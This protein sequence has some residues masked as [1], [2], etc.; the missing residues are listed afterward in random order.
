MST[1]QNAGAPA[2]P[3]SR[4]K[5]LIGGFIGAGAMALGGIAYRVAALPDGKPAVEGGVLTRQEMAAAVAISLALFPPG[6]PFDIDGE[7]ADVA[8]YLD[9]YLMRLPSAEQKIL[10]A[11]IWLYDQGTVMGGSFRSIRMMSAADAQ[12][13][14]RGWETSRF[15]WRR[16]LAMSLRSVF[17]FGY[18]AHPK[19]KAAVFYNEPCH[20]S[21][22]S[23]LSKGAHS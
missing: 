7:Q 9:R 8:G 16:D 20:S 3:V 21:G 23:I 12:A 6:N 22:P 19:V 4:R 2:V 17:G 1:V 15:G 14:V 13:Y 18:F 11:L 5:F 10:R